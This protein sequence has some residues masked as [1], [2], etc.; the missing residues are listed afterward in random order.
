MVLSNFQPTRDTSSARV[1]AQFADFPGVRNF[2]AQEFGAELVTK[3]EQSLVR[4]SRDPFDRESQRLRGDEIYLRIWSPQLMALDGKTP[5]AMAI[6][7]ARRYSTSPPPRKIILDQPVAMA[8]DGGNERVYAL[9]A[10]LKLEPGSEYRLSVRIL[11][12]AKAGR[13]FDF[14]FRTDEQGRPV[15]F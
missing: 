9:P 10:D 1:A 13:A 7:K 6:E 15:P 12:A 8:A 5:V 3:T 14:P 4:I 2:R 11:N